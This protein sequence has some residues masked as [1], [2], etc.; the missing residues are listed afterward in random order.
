MVEF[1]VSVLCFG[2]DDF[3]PF[4]MGFLIIFLLLFGRGTTV[5]QTIKVISAIFSAVDIS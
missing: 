2:Y 5:M 3:Y 1:M 4:L